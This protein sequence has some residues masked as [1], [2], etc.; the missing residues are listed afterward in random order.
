MYCDS[1]HDTQSITFLDGNCMLLL[2]YV[3]YSWMRGDARNPRILSLTLNFA[4]SFH[5]FYWTAIQFHNG[6]RTVSLSQRDAS[7]F[8]ENSIFY[9]RSKRNV[10][11]LI[12]LLFLFLFCDSWKSSS[13]IKNSIRSQVCHWKCDFDFR[14][15]LTMQSDNWTFVTK[16]SPASYLLPIHN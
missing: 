12:S 8:S 4:E 1:R 15:V 11:S 3:I 6:Q 5:F 13:N 16:N 7:H 9:F 2:R 10:Y 14:Y